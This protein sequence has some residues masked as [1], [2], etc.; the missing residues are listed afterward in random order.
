MRV[1][2]DAAGRLVIPRAIRREA[3]LV[4]GEP[5]EVRWRDGRIEIEPA[6]LPVDLIRRG[7][8]LVATPREASTL[9]TAAVVERTRDALRQERSAGA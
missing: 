3:G 8:L 2:I 5:L 7:R 4:P 6:P 9:L 1:T